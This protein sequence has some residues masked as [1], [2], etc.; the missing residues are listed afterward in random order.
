MLAQRMLDNFRPGDI[1]VVDKYYDSY[2]FIALCV[3][4]GVEVVVRKRGRRGWMPKL[5]GLEDGRTAGPSPSSLL[6][7]AALRQSAKANKP[8]VSE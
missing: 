8:T 4:R 3:L 1:V 6:A 5:R 2:W 7:L